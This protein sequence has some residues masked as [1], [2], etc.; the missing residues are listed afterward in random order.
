M[1]LGGNVGACCAQPKFK[2][3]DTD[4]RPLLHYLSSLQGGDNALTMDPDFAKS[5]NPPSVDNH[6][7]RATSAAS[8]QEGIG[9]R[10]GS[11]P[12]N[13]ATERQRTLGPPRG[14]GVNTEVQETRT[15]VVS[16]PMNPSQKAGERGG[17]C[18]RADDEKKCARCQS[19]FFINLKLPCG[20]VV[21]LC[22]TCTSEF[23][24]HLDHKIKEMEARLPP[25]L[26]ADVK[27]GEGGGGVGS[28]A[29]GGSLER[30]SQLGL[31]GHKNFMLPDSLATDATMKFRRK[32]PLGG[33]AAATARLPPEMQHHNHTLNEKNNEHLKKYN[34]RNTELLLPR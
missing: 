32:L 29:E 10:K 31:N 18:G 14:P 3:A 19:K 11:I 1:H 9:I 27:G 28:G 23:R 26:R 7:S 17:L 2:R 8:S 33:R 24:T 4:Q 34:Y 16:R 22:P 25:K 21:C 15:R 20:R 12:A 13:P 30:H 5:C 6:F